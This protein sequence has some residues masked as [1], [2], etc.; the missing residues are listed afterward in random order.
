M[1]VAGFIFLLSLHL[2]V[3]QIGYGRNAST[4][5]AV[6]NIGAMFNFDSIIGR[7]AKIAIDEALKDVNSNSSILKGTKLSV[8]LQDT[9]CNGFLGMVEA[10]RYMATD[11]VAIIGPQ[12]S[13]VA[14]IISHVASELR[15][16][17]LS[18][19][20]TDPT[21]SSLQFPFFC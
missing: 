7:V 3:F 9:N 5:P 15:F 19:A 2:G 6:V 8:T 14:P 16:P 4:R 1:N 21:L 11:V 13:V 18:F 12:C 20:A 10:L 17:L